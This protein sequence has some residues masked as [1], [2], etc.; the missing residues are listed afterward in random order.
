MQRRA[1]IV[2]I[3]EYDNC[4]HLRSAVS[5]ARRME[6]LLARNDDGSVNYTVRSVV[7]GKTEPQITRGRLRQL[8]LD[9]FDGFEGDVLLFFSGHGALTPWG[10]TLVTQDA[11]SDDVGVPMDDVLLL[12]NRSSARDIV[13]V[14]D[15]CHSGDL[16]NPPILQALNKPLSLL[17]EGIT[18]LAA[19]RPNE[20]AYEVNGSGMFTDAL[21]EGL[22]GGAAD[23][24]G[25]VSAAG[26]FL[27]ADR[28]FDAWDQ[29]PIYKSHAGGVATLRT[30]KPAVAHGVLR[31][32][33]THFAREDTT[34]TLDP[35]YEADPS[36]SEEDPGR[37]KKREDG[38]T[39]KML[40]D[41]RLLESV[42]GDDLYWT[43][44]NARAIRL[45]HLG[46]YYWRLL[47]R[48]KL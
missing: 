45:T 21:A 11:T 26:L 35:E 40:R 48:G 19:S 39:F 32:I 9:L 6:E 22:A 16:G 24:L 5:D 15:C 1:L 38:R 23:H 4:S 13:I 29:R 17:R 27:Y 14:L 34:L 30:C 37:A 10:G 2:G 18:V 3:N 25:N 20:V 7:S 47:T 46:R 43:A 8:V 44:M 12:A 41:A 42:D 31:A 36:I 28:L 33:T